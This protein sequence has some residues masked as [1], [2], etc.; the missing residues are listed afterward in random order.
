M[1]R[2]G[3]RDATRP[4]FRGRREASRSWAVTRSGGGPRASEGSEGQRGQ[5]RSSVSHIVGAPSRQV[6]GDVGHNEITTTS[7]DTTRG[8]SCSIALVRRGQAMRHQRGARS[9]LPDRGEQ[10][11]STRFVRSIGSHS[12]AN[13]ERRSG[14]F[15]DGEFRALWRVAFVMRESVLR[16]ARL[17]SWLGAK[18]N[19]RLRSL[20][21]AGRYRSRSIRRAPCEL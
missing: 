8:P 21:R 2:W 10:S 11:R 17:D 5:G 14:V 3:C 7:V 16:L 4:Q 12:Q 19:Q 1:V 6:E 9:C 18:V 15:T 20:T 13:R